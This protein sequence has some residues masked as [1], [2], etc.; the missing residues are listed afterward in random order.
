MEIDKDSRTL[1]L[2][3]SPHLSTLLPSHPATHQSR[4]RKQKVGEGG[5]TATREEEGRRRL[6]IFSD[7]SSFHWSL[8]LPPHP[9]I[10]R[11]RIQIPTFFV[12]IPAWLHLQTRSKRS[13]FFPPTI[14]A[15]VVWK[16]TLPPGF[17]S[18]W[19]FVL[20]GAARKGRGRGRAAEQRI[21]GLE[22]R[23]CGAS[24]GEE[25]RSGGFVGRRGRA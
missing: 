4:C 24:G 23:G 16:K 8:I 5:R 7:L 17:F 3:S 9:P 6:F 14:A 12:A 21:G 15:G 11:S 25:G 13:D 22:I 19:V 2:S 18:F 10:R 1:H 20:G